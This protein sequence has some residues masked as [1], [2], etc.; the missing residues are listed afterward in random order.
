[1]LKKTNI[2]NIK[3]FLLLYL[4]IITLISLSH[5]LSFTSSQPSFAQSNTGKTSPENSQSQDKTSAKTP[6]P[7]SDITSNISLILTPAP[8]IINPSDNIDFQVPE[9]NLKAG[10]GND[11]TAGAGAEENR[12]SEGNSLITPSSNKN[13]TNNGPEDAETAKQTVITPVNP[14]KTETAE[15]AGEPA[16]TAADI[17]SGGKSLVIAGSGGSGNQS[18]ASNGPEAAETANQTVITP[19]ATAANVT[20]SNITA[21]G[22]QSIASN[23]PEAAETANQTVI[24]PANSKNTSSTIKDTG[25]QGIIVANTTS[26]NT[27]TKTGSDTALTGNN[28]STPQEINANNSVSKTTAN[29]TSNKTGEQASS[30][31]PWLDQISKILGVK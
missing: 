18:I 15:S 9:E 12:Y 21:G 30:P 31:F 17:S 22:N 20:S 10:I 7:T 5:F 26:N 25:K 11:E 1:V 24:I 4:I 6:S 8:D 27:N 28:K 13:K 29:S 19:A 23:G 16:S 3:S 14:K 2:H